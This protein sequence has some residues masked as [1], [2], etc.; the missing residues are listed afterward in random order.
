MQWTGPE[1]C[2]LIIFMRRVNVVKSLSNKDQPTTKVSIQLI[3][4]QWQINSAA[5]N[6]RVHG[7]SFGQ[8]TIDSRL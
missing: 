1:P 6:K 4:T 3:T 2:M 5:G 8:T 7:T